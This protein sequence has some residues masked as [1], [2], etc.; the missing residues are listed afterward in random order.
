[1]PILEIPYFYDL[2]YIP[3]GGRNPRSVSVQDTLPLRVPEY[4][5]SD[6]L[7]T[8]LR[9][10]FE[11]WFGPEAR[12]DYQ[13]LKSPD[14]NLMIPWHGRL[15]GRLPENA[16]LNLAEVTEQMG[17]NCRFREYPPGHGWPP[18]FGAGSANT[19]NVRETIFSNRAEAQ[20]E[21]HRYWAKACFVEGVFHVP[22]EGPVWELCSSGLHLHDDAALAP[23]YSAA[24]I[25]DVQSYDEIR[26]LIPENYPNG[27]FPVYGEVHSEDLTLQRPNT[28]WLTTRSYVDYACRFFADKP[29]RNL[30]PEQLE[31]L[32][33]FKRMTADGTAHTLSQPD[34]LIVDT[35]SKLKC[36]AA[37]KRAD[38]F[39]Y[40]NAAPFTRL[41]EKA[42]A[43]DRRLKADAAARE[44]LEPTT[45]TPR[46]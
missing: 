46:M 24:W 45:F 13:Y 40:W 9:V 26:G 23:G 19:L 44:E 22:T 11:Q 2:T 6:M 15:A 32:A 12:W 41:V 1:M 8:D 43:L 3:R 29:V 34:E 35:V 18:S 17:P 28:L 38:N 30:M 42:E 7:E 14:G 37:D 21:A 36:I 31:S 20:R 16:A 25:A 4:S 5:S 39:R 27:P 33:S 10:R